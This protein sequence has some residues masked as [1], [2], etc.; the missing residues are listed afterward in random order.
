M[1]LEHLVSKWYVPCLASNQVPLTNYTKGDIVALHAVP[2]CGRHD[3]PECSRDLSQICEKG[4]H[5]GIGQDGFYAP[6]TCVDVRGLVLVPDG[7]LQVKFNRQIWLTMFDDRGHTCR[8][9]R[10]D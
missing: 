9:C 6:Y 4:H 2:G 1:R 7:K 3:C 5:S 8:G 10:C